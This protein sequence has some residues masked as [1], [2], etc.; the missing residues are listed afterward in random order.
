MEKIIGRALTFESRTTGERQGKQ[1]NTLRTSKTPGTHES[2]DSDLRHAMTT[3]ASFDHEA[4][5]D[6]CKTD[7][8]LRNETQISC[9]FVKRM[10]LLYFHGSASEPLSSTLSSAM[11]Q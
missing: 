3:G 4:Q 2:L 9:D 10:G 8:W 6:L 11:N 7:T 5:R 1:N